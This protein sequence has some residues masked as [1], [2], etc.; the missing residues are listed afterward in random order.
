MIRRLCMASF[1][2]SRATH[3]QPPTVTL[4]VQN[5]RK[6]KKNVCYNRP[7]F[8]ECENRLILSISNRPD[9]FISFFLNHIF[10]FFMTYCAVIK[11]FSLNF[12]LSKNNCAIN[13][14]IALKEKKTDLLTCKKK[15]KTRWLQND[16]K[17]SGQ[18]GTDKNKRFSL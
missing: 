2:N 18:S 15:S 8:F 1:F 11:F 13:L 17:F 14:I 5:K 3:V 9:N 12:F 4:I 7:K 6:Q 16:I 10:F